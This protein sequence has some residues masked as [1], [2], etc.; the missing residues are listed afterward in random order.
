MEGK[1]SKVKLKSWQQRKRKT[2]GLEAPGG[3]AV[4]LIDQV[5]HL[6]HLWKSGDVLQVDEYLEARA[7][8]SHKLFQ[9]V[10]QALIELA[11]EGSEERAL[12]E[13]ISNHLMARS[14][15]GGSEQQAYQQPALL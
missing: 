1:G 3:K 2:L 6:L 14:N 7:L 4:P 9:Q 15:R 12:L 13:S 10:L 8:R 11:H 5:H